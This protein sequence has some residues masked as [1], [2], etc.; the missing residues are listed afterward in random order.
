MSSETA[1]TRLELVFL[2]FF[3]LFYYYSIRI[4]I[5]VLVMKRQNLVIFIFSENYYQYETIQNLGAEFEE[6][7]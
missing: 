7:L 5:I 6:I 3:Y 4:I 1:R 2:S